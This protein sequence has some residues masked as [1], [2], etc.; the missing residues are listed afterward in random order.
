[1]RTALY[2]STPH[3]WQIKCECSWITTDHQ[4]LDSK[5]TA[6][7]D[8]L[9]EFHTH[10]CTYNQ[11]PRSIEEILEI[12]KIQTR[13]WEKRRSDCVRWGHTLKPLNQR[14]AEDCACLRCGA[15]VKSKVTLATYAS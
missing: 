12:K 2:H 4:I 8:A 9:I 15:L 7:K 14:T 5:S 11:R 13:E 10:I 6:L 3:G 1:M